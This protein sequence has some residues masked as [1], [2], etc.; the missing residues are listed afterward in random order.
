LYQLTRGR[1]G[2]RLV[3]NDMLLLTT[4]GA[5]SGRP[6][7]VPLLYLVEGGDLIVIA[8]YGGRDQHPAWYT[9]LL[10]EPSVGVQI[11][12]N[13]F[14]AV[15]T[16]VDT[17]E[18]ARLWPRIV[19]AYSGYAVYQSRTSRQIPVVRIRPLDQEKAGITSR[20][21]SSMPEVS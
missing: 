20:A 15:A 3:A 11:R 17:A 4:T 13:S 2:N 9:N 1:V 19:T 18:R 5:V 12:G 16:T 8:S 14:G 6:H 10:R 21:K 7:T